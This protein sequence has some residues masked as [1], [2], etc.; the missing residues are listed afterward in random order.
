MNARSAS[1]PRWRFASRRAGSRGPTAGRRLKK[2][3]DM[4]RDQAPALF[5]LDEML[6][7]TNS[8]DRLIGAD[9]VIHTLLD[10]RALGLVSTHDLALAQIADSDER[11]VNV[12]FEDRLEDGKMVFDYRIRAGVVRHSNAIALM[13]A[14]GLD[15]READAAPG[16]VG[17]GGKA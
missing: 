16:P 8:H 13:R 10:R 3:V 6:G 5:L 7:G 2:M 9:A 15:V 11:M 17:A 12:H 14:V 4:A 1:K